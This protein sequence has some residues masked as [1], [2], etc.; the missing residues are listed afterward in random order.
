[1][2]GLGIFPENLK[3]ISKGRNRVK[4]GFVSSETIVESISVESTVSG[5][6]GTVG[7]TS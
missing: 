3:R 6:R 5:L 2:E 4:S 1:M 7:G